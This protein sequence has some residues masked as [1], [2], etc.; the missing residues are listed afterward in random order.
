M[1]QL[2]RIIIFP[3]IFWFFLILICFYAFLSHI[4]LPKFLKSIKLRK[5]IIDF[6]NEA[7]I[8]TENK[9]KEIQLLLLNK[10]K[11]NLK[12]LENCIFFDCKQLNL[13]VFDKKLIKPSKLNLCIVSSIYKNMLF[14]NKQVLN[15]INFYPSNLNLR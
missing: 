11:I 15:T 1:P 2:D 9:N 6:N 7:F 3:Q 10:L 8:H 5:K 13:S 14:C 4:F 12:N